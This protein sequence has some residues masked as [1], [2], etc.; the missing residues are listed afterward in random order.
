MHYLIFYL[1]LCLDLEGT[2]RESIALSE[3]EH[4]HMVMFQDQNSE[5][6]TSGLVQL[7]ML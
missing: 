2:P 1:V 5:T 3:A 7:F 6:D 4:G